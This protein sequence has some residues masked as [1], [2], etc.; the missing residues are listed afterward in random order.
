MFKFQTKNFW[1]LGILALVI[2]CNLM[3]GYRNLS[4]YA[5]EGA[6]KEEEAFYVA[7]KAFEDGFC[8]VSLSLLERFQ[9]A[10]PASQKTAQADLLIGQC[11]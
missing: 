6:S 10:Y 4:L 1:R 11:Y 7:Q 2:A 3:P 8:D 9:A 5:Q